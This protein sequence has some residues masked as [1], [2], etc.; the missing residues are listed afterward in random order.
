MK[1][2]NLLCLLF[3]FFFIA[4]SQ[5]YADKPLLDGPVDGREIQTQQELDLLFGADPAQELLLSSADFVD[6][7]IEFISSTL[8]SNYH[9]IAVDG[10]YAYCALTY[11]LVIYDITDSANP[12]QISQLELCMENICKIGDYLYHALDGVGVKVIDVSDPY[13]PFVAGEYSYDCNAYDIDS[14]GNLI[15]VFDSDHYITIF[16]VSDPSHPDSLSSY[17][18][19]ATPRGI[20]VMDTIL[21]AALYDEGLEILS[22]ADPGNLTYLGSYDAAADIYDVYVQD[23]L[24]F[25]SVD[26][27]GIQVLNVS[28]PAAPVFI[29]QG[30]YLNFGYDITIKDSV[31]FVRGGYVIAYNISDIFNISV[32]DTIESEATIYEYAVR[33]NLFFIAGGYFGFSI[34]DISDLTN[35]QPIGTD[36]SSGSVRSQ[37]IADTLAYLGCWNYGLQVVNISDLGHP[38][39][40]GGFY[41][42]DLDL[43]NL[44]VEDGYAYTAG[45]SGFSVFDLTDPSNPLQFYNY[46]DTIR[47]A[48]AVAYSNGFAYVT[49]FDRLVVFDVSNP[50]NPD[51]ISSYEIDAASLRYNMVLRDTLLYIPNYYG[52]DVLIIVNISDPYNPTLAGT[53]TASS[54]SRINFIEIIEDKAYSLGSRPEFAIIDLSN[55]VMPS[56]LGEYNLI[57]GTARRL[58]VKDGTVF[59]ANQSNGITLLDISDPGN[60]YIFGNYNTPGNT[61][62][63][64]VED[65]I[66]YIA[67]YSGFSIYKQTSWIGKPD[68]EV[69]SMAV[70]SFTPDSIDIYC[71]L[72]NTGLQPVDLEGATVDPGDNVKIAAYLS[73]D[74][75]PGNAGDLLVG[76]FN[77]QDSPAGLLLPA[78]SLDLIISSPAVVDTSIYTYL[79]VMLD[80][81]NSVIEFDENNNSSSDIIGYI[82]YPEL[83]DPIVQ[84]AQCGNINYYHSSYSYVYE[85]SVANWD[86]FP[87]EL[88]EPAP[89]LPPCGI[90]TNAAR[91]WVDIYSETGAYLYGFCAF[92]ENESLDNLWF[93]VSQ[94]GQHPDSIYIVLTDRRCNR[95]YISEMMDVSQ[96]G[97]PPVVWIIDDHLE[98]TIFTNYML[99]FDVYIEG[100][101]TVTGTYDGYYNE[102]NMRYYFWPQNTGRHNVR[103]TGFNDCGS[104]TDYAYFDIVIRFVRPTTEWIN[105]YCN[106][107]SF[108]G[109]PLSP[110]D[111][112]EAYDPDGVLCGRDFVRE[113]GSFG[114][115]PIYRDDSYSTNIDEGAEPGDIITFKINSQDVL[116]TVVWT[117]FG[118]AYEICDFAT[119]QC[120][121]YHLTEGW[122][123]ISWNVD[124]SGQIENAIAE[125]MDCVD[126]VMSFDMSGLSYVPELAEYSTLDYLDYYHGY[127]FKMGCD[128]DLEICGLPLDPE[129]GISIR[130]GWNLV[131]YWPG[132]SATVEQGWSSIY[133]CLVAA[134]GFDN[135]GQTWW[136]DTPGYNTLEYLRPGFGYWLKSSCDTILVYDGFAYPAYQVSAAKPIVENGI[137]ATKDWMSVYGKGITID[138]EPIEDGNVIEAY[139]CGGVL[140]GRGI[141]SD[142]V[143]KFMPVYGREKAN[144]G[145]AAYPAQTDMVEIYINGEKTYPSLGWNSNGE[146]ID[147]SNRLSAKTAGLPETFELRQNYPNPFNPM[148]TIEYSIPI[149]SHVRIAI[150][151]ILGQNIR[152]LVDETQPAGNYRIDWDGKAEDGKSVSSGIYFYRFLAGDYIQTKKLVLLK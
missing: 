135:G 10:N 39:V 41:D 98:M 150:Y 52:P 121:Q 55:P 91:T 34:L 124:Y 116:T 104:R 29:S 113:D 152:M 151:N 31:C 139:T 32:I 127:W 132:D 108:N 88:F 43:N 40:I 117:E 115:M 24:A 148:T 11:G 90:N 25:I 59:L 131:S 97:F 48:S 68:L 21:Y 33:N 140:C 111:T 120:I 49:F 89:D 47:E 30:P 12:V 134:L 53:L 87:D 57:P 77:I 50:A 54:T 9:D 142:N 80:P 74:T 26:N 95:Q 38:Q 45:R 114:Y 37:F 67:D 83:P 14:H 112:I 36:Q 76:N 61:Y 18:L 66:I 137:T 86:E 82:C 13:N 85:L 6:S 96:V 28:D 35:P 99:W 17:A 81:E 46:P 92:E 107:A 129:N 1:P 109:V 119:E 128:A 103:V 133:E 44:V 100:A 63:I 102:N 71:R 101:D 143:L 4:H 125:I 19:N 22:I 20:S 93:A 51:S 130:T 94:N 136:I 2:I 146:Y 5:S 141:Y 79:V 105:V 123:L 3:S 149:K 78:A 122:H 23:S 15:F 69:D 145:S 138:G 16:D 106:S 58:T 73:A 56:I 64:H 118:D 8:W 70:S 42:L 65:S 60:P 84:V 126:V 144:P 72:K 75:I 62:D 7:S 110:G 147:I 27:T